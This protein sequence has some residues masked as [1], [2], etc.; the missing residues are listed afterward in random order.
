LKTS[1]PATVCGGSV[2]YS[3]GGTLTIGGAVG[4]VTAGYAGVSLSAGASCGDVSCS[5]V[6]GAG[7]GCS[8]A[9]V[10]AGGSGQC[11]VGTGATV[12]S[13]A[14]L[15]GDGW[16]F[17][18]GATF[19]GD[20]DVQCGDGQEPGT[21]IGDGWKVN[22]G[23]GGGNITLRGGNSG[24]LTVG[25]PAIG[26]SLSF[27]TIS[28]NGGTGIIDADAMGATDPGYAVWVTGGFSVGGTPSAY[29]GPNVQILPPFTA[30]VQAPGTT[31]FNASATDWEATRNTDPGVANVL[32]PASGGPAGWQFK[33][34]GVNRVGTYTPPAGGSPPRPRRF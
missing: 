29:S 26:Q 13:G 1:L 15:R 30:A 11:V 6:F 12:A 28:L 19:L 32:A 24:G 9:S 20:M 23:T 22:N 21:S 25:S 16:A 2:S 31:V 17:D 4:S 5:G 7:N 34:A 10:N 14:S 33:S 8:F 27:G 3:G 18:T